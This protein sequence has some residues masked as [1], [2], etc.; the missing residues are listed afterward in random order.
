MIG[1]STGTR[2]DRGIDLVNELP[3]NTTVSSDNSHK[4]GIDEVGNGQD[5]TSED[6][7]GD[8][9]S[10][11]ACGDLPCASPVSY[12]FTVSASDSDEEETDIKISH[13]RV[14][15]VVRLYRYTSGAS[16]ISIPSGRK[17]QSEGSKCGEFPVSSSV[18]DVSQL[19][20]LH[21]AEC[22]TSRVPSD[23]KE[24]QDLPVQGCG[25]KKE[26][27]VEQE[28]KDET[29]RRLVEIPSYRA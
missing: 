10:E 19:P 13:I 28:V 6:T 7:Q 23:M 21:R 3:T 29:K 16:I 18:I 25:D 26:A 15:Q 14:A 4:I 22:T 12:S 1:S 20:D 9:I 24:A 5:K 8:D 11:R 27:K 2:Q 17:T